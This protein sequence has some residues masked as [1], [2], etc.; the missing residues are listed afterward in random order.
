MARTVKNQVYLQANFNPC[1]YNFHRKL[2][3]L[4]ILSAIDPGKIGTMEKL[5]DESCQQWSQERQIHFKNCE[6]NDG[7]LTTT[8]R[9]QL[10]SLA[11][12]EIYMSATWRGFV[13]S[14]ADK[15]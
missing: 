13:C 2:S 8:H 9:P 1:F 12:K 5:I 4:F 3:K 15:E 7:P 11:A 6:Q 14:L 10:M